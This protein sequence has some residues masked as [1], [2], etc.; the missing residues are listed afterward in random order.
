MK[1]LIRFVLILFVLKLFSCDNLSKIEKELNPSTMLW[2]DKPAGSWTEAMPIGNGRLGAMVYGGTVNETIQFNEETLWT[3]QP[4]DYANKEAYKVLDELRQLLSEGK[5]KQAHKLGNERFMS[6]P[7]GQ[8]SYQPF[9]NILLN[10]PKHEKAINFKRILNLE[11]AITTVSYEIDNIKFK[12]EALVSKPNQAIL[13]RIEASKKGKLNF[14]IGLNS[15]HSKYDVIV[16]GNE[17]ILK[18]KAN[19]YPRALDV[20]KAPYPESKITFEARL[21]IVNDGGKL[22]IENDTIKVV[23]ANTATIQLVAATSFVNF[24]DISG[25]PAQLCEN[26]LKG[27]NGKS[28]KELKNNHIKDFQKLFNRVELELGT[29]EISNR[30]TNERLISFEQDED[31]SLV[32]LLFQYGRYLL[33]SS[34]RAGTQP[35]NLQGIWNDQL[36]PSWDSKYTLNINAEMNYWLAE[37][38]NLSELTSPMI[39]MVEDLAVSGQNVAKEHYNLDGWVAHHNTDLWRGAAP[40]NNSNHGIWVTGGAW[41]CK[42]LWWHYQFT[43]NKEYLKNKAYPILKEASRF[44]VGYL[45]PDPNNPKWL[46]SGPS[47]S[48]ENGGLVMGPTMDHQII[49]NLFSNTI[50]AA[51]ILGVDAEFVEMIKEK[52]AKIAPNLIGQ[53]GQLQ[54]W[55]VDKDNPN[56]EHR[57]VSHLWGLHPGN[58]IHPLT[59]PNLAEACKITLKHRGD[60]GTGWSRAWKINF[61]ARLLDGDHSF[62]ILKNLMVPAITQNPDGKK[63]EGGGLYVN[64]FDAHPPFQIDGNFGATSGITEMLLQSHLRDEK[65]DYFQDILPALPS[66]LSSGKISG[67]KGRGAFELSIEWKNG[68]LVTVEVKSIEG[69]NLNLRYGKKMISRETT[70]G[71]IL[72]FVSS[73]FK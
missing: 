53:H 46:I 68:E 1:K 36:N 51:E 41:L 57:H 32:S 17:I 16:N 64:L 66:T 56:N 29:S 27:L 60:G 54:E 39:Q 50:E 26:Y 65:G 42:H 58:E 47:N 22:V 71:E 34:S 11:N 12:R 7:F 38:T 55:L 20:I 35:A 37:I 23:N 21:K 18:G 73:D 70:K 2:Y 6:Q 10:F 43:N 13:I 3:G 24:K 5:Q 30:P 14:T 19:N 63:I 59:T 45:T 72:S 9:G 61:W 44:F 62:L 40:I 8:F 67:I 69:N 25:N 28:Y 48:P 33:I 52:R 4:H 31:P 15:P 49:R